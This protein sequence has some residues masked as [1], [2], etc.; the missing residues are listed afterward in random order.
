MEEQ[1]SLFELNVDDGTAREMSELTRWTRLFGWMVVS[2]LAIIALFL[3]FGANRLTALF[4]EADSDNGNILASSFMVVGL[5]A[6]CIVGTMMFFLIRS[7]NRIRNGLLARD[8]Q[9]FNSGL[10][11]LKTYFIFMGIFGILSLVINL[12]SLF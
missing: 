6:T 4:V 12:T 10:G 2:L 3:V 7:A 8:Q 9:L 5:L 1:K 11:D